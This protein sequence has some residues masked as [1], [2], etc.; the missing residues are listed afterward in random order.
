MQLL[1]L[2]AENVKRLVAVRLEFNKE[3][4]MLVI[5]GEN[6]AGKSSVLDAIE[7][8]LGGAESIPDRPIRS[9]ASKARIVLETDAFTITRTFTAKGTNLVITGKDGAAMAQPQA[10]LD[11]V[12]NTLCLD[13]L[14]FTRLEAKEQAAELRRLVGIDFTALDKEREEKYASRTHVNREVKTQQ[15]RVDGMQRHPEVP[16]EPKKADEILDR[17]EKAQ[18]LNKANAEARG[19]IEPA[20]ATLK[21]REARR[22]AAQ[23]AFE[24]AKRAL[25][26]AEAAYSD[27][28]EVRDEIEVEIRD[29][30][31]VDEAPL[32]EELKGV[33]DVNAKVAANASWQRENERLVTLTKQSDAL[34]V[35][36]KEIDSEK[37]K[38]L[39]NAKFPI[40]G[41]SFTSEGVTFR[42]IPFGQVNSA[43]QLRVSVAM[44]FAMQPKL[45]LALIR[46]GVF[47]SASSMALVARMAAD[48]GATVLVERVGDGKEVQVIIEDGEV[49][50]DRRQ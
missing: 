24:D 45:K 49:Q 8:A 15:T 31:D 18:L 11:S 37:E 44:A 25:Q 19:R 26:A 16:K 28:L 4:N 20:N 1:A 34:S 17:L 33:Q 23:R 7:M 41:L 14:K 40:E 2:E 48:A 35:R 46:E 22:A 47:L 6:G 3:Q 5:G 36:I 29:L 21:E 38:A 42:D 27:A 10:L 12:T 13:P 32:L 30:V 50:E 39:S 9:G 43:E